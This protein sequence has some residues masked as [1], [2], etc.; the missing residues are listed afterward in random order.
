MKLIS[1][2]FSAIA[3]CSFAEFG[4]DFHLPSTA[5]FRYF[6]LRHT[7]ATP[8]WLARKFYT[9]FPFWSI[10]CDPTYS[11]L[12]S[13]YCS[14]LLH[15][16]TSRLG[17]TE[18]RLGGVYQNL[19]RRCG[20]RF[21]LYKSL[22]LF[23]LETKLFRQHFCIGLIIPHVSF[24]PLYPLPCALDVL[25]WLARFVIHGMRM[26]NNWTVWVRSP[27]LSSHLISLYPISV[28]V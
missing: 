18:S 4:T 27:F 22:Q 19:W 7:A 15:S 12:I 9:T 2:L 16:K 28:I 17:V 11:K 26:S 25:Q 21:S 13:T 6:Q 20:R 23:L 5:Y 8:F 3:F 10:Y 14:S 24:S 1:H